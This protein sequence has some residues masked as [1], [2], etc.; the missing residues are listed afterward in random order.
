GRQA[1][2]RSVAFTST[3]RPLTRHGSLTR[4]VSRRPSGPGPVCR[5]HFHGPAAD[6]SRLT[7]AQ[8]EPWAVRPRAGMS[9][10]LAPARPRTRHGSRVAIFAVLSD[11][12]VQD[13]LLDLRLAVQKLDITLGAPDRAIVPDRACTAEF[14]GGLGLQLVTHQFGIVLGSSHDDMHVITP[15]SH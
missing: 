1:P 9:R 11:G 8:R 13:A 12:G 7:H 10:S 2:G 15:H 14:P 6:A 4:N 3:A 5:V